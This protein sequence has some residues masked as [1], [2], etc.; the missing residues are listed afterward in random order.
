MTRST[1]ILAYPDVKEAFDK[2]LS[3][4]GIRV[5]FKD[6]RAATRFAFRCNAFRVLD[7]KE[8]ATL[9]EASHTLHGRSVYDSLKVTRGEGFVEIVPLV[10]DV[11]SVTEL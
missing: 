4:R 11:D 2:A 1:S 6:P 5:A 7:R 10:L 3:G 8:N 9:Y